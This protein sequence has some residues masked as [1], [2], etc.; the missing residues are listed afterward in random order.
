MLDDPVREPERESIIPMINVV[1]LLL[2]FFLMTAQIAPPEPFDVTPP[3]SASDEP[4]EAPLTLHV[5][6]SGQLGF[7]GATGEDDVFE[8][9]TAER[10]AICEVSPDVR[11]EDAAEA[12]AEDPCAEPPV[13]M[14]RADLGLPG[15]RLAALLPRIATAGFS[16]AQIVTALE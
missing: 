10:E 15:D 2:I 5:D 3:D 9:L 4:A 11:A 8:A 1:F 13:L 16:R 7:Q 12:G 14:I 6:A